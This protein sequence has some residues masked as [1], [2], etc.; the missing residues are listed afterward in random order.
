MLVTFFSFLV[1]ICSLLVSFW[2]LLFTFCLLLVTFYSLLFSYENLRS[3]HGLLEDHALYFFVIFSTYKRYMPL[4]MEVH[5]QKALA[6]QA[7]EIIRKEENF[8]KSTKKKNFLKSTTTN[9]WTSKTPISA[10]YVPHFLKKN[11]SGVK[12]YKNGS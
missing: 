12:T 2:S 4:S 11:N 3:L 7:L 8:L 9:G 6:C 10:F 5:V 1:T